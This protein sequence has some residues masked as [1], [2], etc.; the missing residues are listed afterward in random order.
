MPIIQPRP[1]WRSPLLLLLAAHLALATLFSLIVPLGEA[2]D[3][4]DHYAYVVYIG[5]HASLPVGPAVTQGKH[6]PLYHGLGALLTAWTGLDFNFLRANP[7]AQHGPDA[8]YPNH[9]IH[10]RLEDFP[11]HGGALAM[12]ILRLFSVLLSTV[13]VWGVFALARTLAPAQPGLALA[14]AGFAGFLPGFLFS[15]GTVSNDNLAAALGTLILLLALRIYR[16]GWTNR[17]GLALGVLLGLGLMSKISVLTLWPVAALAVFLAR[18][19]P[20]RGEPVASRVWPWQARIGATVLSLTP[21]GL[22]A[23]PWL[24]RNWILYHDLLGWSLVR[25]TVDVRQGPVDFSVLVWLANGLFK[26]FWGKF[27]AAGQI[28]YPAWLYSLLFALSLAA[29]GGLVL[30]GLR[31][32]PGQL[33]GKHDSSHTTPSRQRRDLRFKLP[34]SPAADLSGAGRLAALL[35]LSVALSLLTL[36]QYT[37]L[38]LGTDQARLLWPVIGP[39]AI[40]FVAGLQGL[41]RRLGPTRWA[42]WAL[43]PAATLLLALIA[44]VG[45][46]RPAYGRPPLAAA[47]PDATPIVFGEELALLDAQVDATRHAPGQPVTVMLTWQAIQPPTQDWRVTVALR[48]PDDQALLADHTNAPTHG[49]WPTDRWRTGDVFREVIML[50]P[51][52]EGVR[53]SR[54]VVTVQV[55]AFGAGDGAWLPVRGGGQSGVLALLAPGVPIAPPDLAAPVDLGAATGLTRDVAATFDQ[56]MTLAAAGLPSQITPDQPLT[57]TLAWVASAA[58]PLNLTAF[59]HLLSADGAI[60]AQDDHQPTGGS[61]PTSLWRPGE[62]SLEVYTLAVPPDAP[63]GPVTLIAGLYHAPTAR[64]VPVLD[65]AGQTAGDHVALITLTVAR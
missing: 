15:S 31:T 4:A 8:I 53:P 7:D 19:A 35:A 44:A 64:R 45:F 2:P 13:T 60:L 21:A 11:W 32:Q 58:Q 25:A 28:E 51:P 56:G 5:T 18:P 39:L 30:Y 6:P 22:I 59:V 43:L 9:F 62:G 61:Y 10:T 50:T 38:A 48:H 1:R 14:A 37:G 36:V 3:E 52:A 46:V 12:H 63:A 33:P 26:T 29:L 57:V 17:R 16:G 65:Q 23:A 20:G 54:Y 27:G 40:G 41:A 34:A 55:R 24:L 47:R 49:R 42:L